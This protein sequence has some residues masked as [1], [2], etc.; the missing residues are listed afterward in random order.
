MKNLRTYY[1]AAD[2]PGQRWE[3][4]VKAKSEKDALKIADRLKNGVK[5]DTV[6]LHYPSELY[7]P[8][9]GEK[10]ILDPKDEMYIM[11]SSGMGNPHRYSYETLIDFGFVESFGLCKIVTF[12]DRNDGHGNGD[13]DE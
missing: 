8:C 10:F 7:R 11:E 6:R 3:A 5:A 13:L 2:C 12:I 4:L 1:V 9:D